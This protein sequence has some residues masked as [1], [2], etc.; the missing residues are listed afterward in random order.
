MKWNKAISNAG[1]LNTKFHIKIRKP[2]LKLRKALFKRGLERNGE[3]IN[4]LEFDVEK[5]GEIFL[6]FLAL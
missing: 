4:V 5:D 6:H 1:N 2:H 3:N